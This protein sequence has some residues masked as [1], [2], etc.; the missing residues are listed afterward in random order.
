MK[1]KFDRTGGFANIPVSI[2]MDTA[3]LEQEKAEELVKLV[4]NVL[5]SKPNA[6]EEQMP[7]SMQYHLEVLN[8]NDTK[9]IVVMNDGNL[10]D[11][12]NDLM[13]FLFDN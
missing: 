13:D 2:S 10:T 1:I 3:N 12:M 6:K 4:S 11:S 9:E 7:D 5:A 8:S